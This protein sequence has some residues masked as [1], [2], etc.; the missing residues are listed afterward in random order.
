MRKGIISICLAIGFMFPVAAAGQHVLPAATPANQNTVQTTP[1]PPVVNPSYPW[2]DTA[3]PISLQ[4]A[5]GRP[6]G[7]GVVPNPPGM[8]RNTLFASARQQEE[9][10]APEAAARAVPGQ[11]SDASNYSFEPVQSA[12]GTDYFQQGQSVV[13]PGLGITDKATAAPNYCDRNC[14][15]TGLPC[16]QGCVKR[17]FGT[18][19]R[20]LTVGGWAQLG[21]H[22]RNNIMFNNLANEWNMHQVWLY[23]EKST[24][25]DSMNWSTGFRRIS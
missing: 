14:C 21:F 24:C 1:A 20:G 18:S 15:Q 25:Y 19:P 17:L 13:E 22:N 2:R 7:T 3:P 11:G 10:A 9:A 8:Q 6:A 16:R 4:P 12:P 5:S 23:A